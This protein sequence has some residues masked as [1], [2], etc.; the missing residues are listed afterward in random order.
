MSDMSFNQARDLAERLELTEVT[1][2]QTLRN[3]NNA[4]KV[5]DITLVKQENIVKR[6]PSMD[7]QL[8]IMKIIV[9]TN[10]GFVLGLLVAKYMI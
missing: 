9:A 6:I 7:K 4:T 10:I 2:K 8:N 3:I 5:L 1:L